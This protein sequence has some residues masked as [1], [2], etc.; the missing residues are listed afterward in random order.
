MVW[1]CIRQMKFINKALMVA[2]RLKTKSVVVVCRKVDQRCRSGFM[3][4]EGI[5]FLLSIPLEEHT[6]N[7]FFVEA[8]NPELWDL[9]M[10]LDS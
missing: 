8:M 7:L 6:P 2:D 5:D 10:R 9:A 1:V 4:L 3:V